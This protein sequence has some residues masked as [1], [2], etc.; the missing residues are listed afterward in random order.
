MIEIKKENLLPDG[1]D[2]E[3]YSEN[4]VKEDGCNKEK[5]CCGSSKG[6]CGS[7]KNN[8]KRCCGR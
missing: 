6:C 2:Y 1:V 7:S 4:V 5:S 3:D 8:D